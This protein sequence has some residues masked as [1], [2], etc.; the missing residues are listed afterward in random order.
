M[1]YITDDDDDCDVHIV[2]N[3]NHFNYLPKH[4]RNMFQ[5][6]IPINQ[7]LSQGLI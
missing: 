2:A 5:K 1:Q 3:T 4:T 6:F 7:Y